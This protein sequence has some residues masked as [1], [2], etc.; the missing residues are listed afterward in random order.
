[1]ATAGGLLIGSDGQRL[2]ALN[3]TTGSELWSFDTGGQISAPPMTY[4]LGAEQ[5]IAVVAGQDL[6]TFKLPKPQ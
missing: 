6:I 2:Y 3:A 5:V 4:R 1:M